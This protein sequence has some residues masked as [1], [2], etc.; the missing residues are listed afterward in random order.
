MRLRLKAFNLMLKASSFH[1]LRKLNNSNDHTASLKEHARK[2]DAFI[3]RFVKKL[4]QPL[5]N[6]DDKH[7]VW[8]GD[9]SKTP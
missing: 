8:I 1:E 7:K 9:R 3:A 5:I 6:T 4:H 2:S